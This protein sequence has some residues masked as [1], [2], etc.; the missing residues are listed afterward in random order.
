MPVERYGVLKGHPL[1]WQPERDLQRP[2]FQIRVLAGRRHW[3][4]AVNVRSALSPPNLLYRHI[5]DFQHEITGR[6]PAL[7]DGFTQLPSTAA[8]GGLALDYL[9]Q[10]L[11]TRE[12]M[13]TA[14]HSAPG[15]GNDL[16]DFL[17]ACLQRTHGEPSA[18]L[19]AFGSAWGPLRR[20]DPVFRFR[21]GR[22]IHNVHMNQGNASRFQADDGTWQ[23][24]ALLFHLPAKRRWA[25]ILLAF[26]SQCWRTDDRTG[27]CIGEPVQA[28]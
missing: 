7:D 14:P 5:D 22:G 19:Y 16:N 12:S 28:E 11:A 24:G 21:P 10:G 17:T 8:G 13:R 4:V 1:Q 27:R 18:R 6:L 3:R 20:P 2:H 23:D 26:Q 15:P 9:R 25:A